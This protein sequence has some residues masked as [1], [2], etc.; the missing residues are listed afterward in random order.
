MEGLQRYQPYKPI[1]YDT[2]L[3]PVSLATAYNLRTGVEQTPDREAATS[4]AI[5][6]LEVETALSTVLRYEVLTLFSVPVD[7]EEIFD[8]GFV[9]GYELVQREGEKSN[10]RLPIFFAADIDSYIENQRLDAR[11]T[12]FIQR[13]A[14]DMTENSDSSLYFLEA[15]FER[16]GVAMS[17]REKTYFIFGFSA[18]FDF[19]HHQIASDGLRKIHVDN[20]RPS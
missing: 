20:V 14:F 13:V 15:Y 10:Q 3:F 5:D 16:F 19:L 9:L 6:R 11:I 2:N 7:Y 12:Y 17:E 18:M 1:D 8:Q 4:A